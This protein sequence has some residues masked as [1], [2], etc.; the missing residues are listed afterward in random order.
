MISTQDYK[1]LKYQALHHFWG[2]RIFKNYQEEI[3]DSVLNQKNTI[4]LLPTGAGKSLC[5][6]LPALLLEGTCIVISPLLA[7]M[8]DQ[9]YALKR[10][11]IEAE[12]ISSEL[13]ESQIEEVLSKCKEGITKLL[14]ISPERLKNTSFLNQ[15]LNVQI[16]FLAVDE[17]HCISEW[18]ADFRPSY[19][20]IKHFRELFNGI[21]T[22]ALTATATPKVLQEIATKLDLKQTSLFQKS[23]KR[24]NISIFVDEITDKYQWV[25]NFL[26]YQNGSGIIY[27]RTRKEAEN[28]T[29]FLQ[30][31]NIKTVN[32]Y[33]AGLSKK[34]KNNRQ[35]EWQKSSQHTLIATNAFG[36]GIDKDNVRFIVH[37]SASSSIENYYQEIGRAGRDGH[38]S[39]AFLL[40]NK[41]EMQQF[42]SILQNAIPNKTEFTKIV[43]YLYSIFQIAE[44][45]L[46]EK[47]FQFQIQKLQKLVGYSTAKVKTVLQFLHHQEIIYYNH[48]KSLS[49]IFLK[50]S[51]EEL[52][53]LL[54]QDA[55]FA[56]ILLRNI[57]GISHRKVLFNEMKLSERIGVDVALIK[58]RIKDLENHHHIEYIDG[59][60]SSI[61]FLQHRDS[62]KAS[63][64]YWRLFFHIQKNKIQK[65]E[66]MK[67]FFQNQK[68]CKMQLILSYFGEKKTQPCGKCSYCQKKKQ[69]I[70]GENITTDIL[71]ILS[72]KPCHID[73]IAIGLPYYE[74]G[75]ILEN[76][77][78]LLDKGKVKMLDFRTYILT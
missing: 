19:Q 3:I 45:E 69:P 65:W 26:Q 2:H 70:F 41:E 52:H 73:E 6:Q 63:G 15:I 14:Y 30:R 9:V 25:Y 8:K 61:R 60:L 71:H 43:A 49:S 28:L 78:L 17:A 39:H 5:F 55:Y 16:S 42:D 57:P 75:I 56:E 40:W 59:A 64:E 33:H 13:E 54:P 72:K 24:E 77:I 7:L 66:D 22:I 23:F 62:R 67:F 44:G 11:N 32:F 74:K 27:T 46:P 51:P 58:Q 10:K 37:Y 47:S 68:H 53:Y 76:L 31:K 36:M 18:G 48:F 35:K 38:T 4:A 12:F 34:E 29:H 20:Y 1:N 50:V 21:T